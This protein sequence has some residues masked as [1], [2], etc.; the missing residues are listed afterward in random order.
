MELREIFAFDDM[1]VI[2]EKEK[3]PKHAL[4]KLTYSFARADTKNLNGRVYPESIL[5]RE[6]NRKSEELRRQKVVGQLDHPLSG[7][8][9]LDKA[10]HVVS[11]ISYDRNSKLGYAE[12][13]VLDTTGGR[14]FMTLLRTGIKMGASMRGYGEVDTD[15]RVKNSFKLETIDFVLRPSFDADATIDQT[16]LI[17]SANFLLGKEENKLKE[18]GKLKESSIRILMEMSY[19]RD[20]DAGIF[21][22]SFE[23]WKAKGGELSTRI[24]VLEVE[25]NLTY[26]EALRI[27]AGKEEGEKILQKERDRQVKVTA[28]DV[29]MEA[30]ICGVDPAKMA[31]RIN[32]SLE[33]EEEIE[34]D[35]TLTME[36]TQAVLRQAQE[37]GM[38][39]SDPEVKEKVLGQAREFKKSQKAQRLEEENSKDSW[40]ERVRKVIRKEMAEKE[41]RSLLLREQMAIDEESS[42]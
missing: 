33:Q 16:N 18:T 7:I 14:D 34:A 1:D 29:A 12:S 31:E 15:G 38:N 25:E 9:N 8:T 32:K 37:A 41:R 36:E 24:A 28:K 39:I 20:V 6:I 30:R 19:N 3:L 4:A 17:E 5:A 26:E 11:D 23:E 40:E 35:G 27:V 22:G 21:R 2:T 42:E 13:L 10:M